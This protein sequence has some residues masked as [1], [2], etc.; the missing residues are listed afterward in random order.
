MDWTVNTFEQYVIIRRNCN[1]TPGD[2]AGGRVCTILR[3]AQSGLNREH[4]GQAARQYADPGL[5]SGVLAGLR[6]NEG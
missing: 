6:E 2:C 3:P 4:T 5:L 1:R